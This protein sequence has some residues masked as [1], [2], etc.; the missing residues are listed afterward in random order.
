MIKNLG[1]TAS[2]SSGG[3][4]LPG[5][6][7]VSI[8]DS[9]DANG[10]TSSTY[11]NC[12]AMTWARILTGQRIQYTHANKY[13]VGGTSWDAI[14][15]QGDTALATSPHFMFITGGTNAFLTGAAGVATQLG[16]LYQTLQACEAAGVI[17]IIAP[18][19]PRADGTYTA[20]GGRFIEMYNQTLQRIGNGDATALAAAGITTP[21]IVLDVSPWWN[22]SVTTGAAATG[23]L[24]TDALHWG[25]GG[26]YDFGKQIA[27][28]INKIMPARPTWCSSPYDIIEATK[29]PRGSLLFVGTRNEGNFQG[30][31]SN[32]YLFDSGL[33]VAPSGAAADGWQL[34]RSAGTSTATMV[35][36][37]IN[38]PDGYTGKA[39][40]V[41]IASSSTGDAAE[42]YL[43]RYFGD[44]D[45]VTTDFSV[46]DTVY[47]EIRYE[48]T[49]AP[50]NLTGIQANLR[51][52]GPASPV[53]SSD[54]VASS[55]AA[56]GL[57]GSKYIHTGV[58]RTPNRVLQT[59]TTSIDCNVQMHMTASTTG[60]ALEIVFTDAALRKV[61]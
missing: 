10:T 39:Q 53:I 43:M 46:G 12:G 35:G 27:D 52:V 49:A 25:P 11:V 57:T 7:F 51:E 6:K 37:I 8:G 18:I 1:S 44:G 17:A 50:T 42:A 58:L 41:V 34:S 47:F 32:G 4:G 20:D 40:K 56:A 48:I 3:G 19:T 26:G 24:G 31:G 28:Y 21:P 30:N 45:Q 5:P 59:G 2:A 16:Y 9:L 23:F 60:G 38:R 33:G 54:G 14:K 15:T 29:N 55:N 61:V 13:S 22:Y 36:S